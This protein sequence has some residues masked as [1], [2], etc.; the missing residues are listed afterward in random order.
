MVYKMENENL[1]IFLPASKEVVDF[2]PDGQSEVS[3]CLNRLHNTYVH[4]IHPIPYG[5]R[6]AR[7][8]EQISKLE[9]LNLPQMKNVAVDVVH[10]GTDR[11]NEHFGNS[12]I[13][14][15]IN[16]LSQKRTLVKAPTFLHFK[17]VKVLFGVSGVCISKDGTVD[18]ISTAI[19]DRDLIAKPPCNQIS[20]GLITLDRFGANNI[21]HFL[22]DCLG[23]ERAFRF[24]EKS[25][26]KASLMLPVDLPQ[27]QSAWVNQITNKQYYKP[28]DSFY[29]RD[30]FVSSEITTDFDEGYSHPANFGDP[31][32]L[33][34][35]KSIAPLN[36]TPSKAAKIYLSRRDSNRRVLENEKKLE[37]FLAELGFECVAMS[38]LN[39]ESQLALMSTA[40]I[41]IAQHG[42]ALTN[43]ITCSPK[44]KV[45]EL[46]NFTRGTDAYEVI[47]SGL[48]LDY[49]VYG[50]TSISGSHNSMIDLDD[51]S[52]FLKKIIS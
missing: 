33:T 28:G 39:A 8:F 31:R 49:H 19:T 11:V 20:K 4:D 45:I 42:A 48:S 21:C 26:E 13:P 46:F 41:V 44:T 51:F 9:G 27:Y 10:F 16:R 23:R 30:L 47:S 3:I 2:L 1:R 38:E 6:Q 15:S 50:M 32:I 24:C 37:I 25:T 29:F 12:K 43:L 52:K 35:L 7:L 5:V 40:E 36:K 18:P 14:P 22:F 34:A 17:D